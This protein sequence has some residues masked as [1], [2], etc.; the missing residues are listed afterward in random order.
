MTHAAVDGRFI[1]RESLMRSLYRLGAVV[2]AATIIA[3]GVAAGTS[4]AKTASHARAAAA[5]KIA[6]VMP[7]STCASRFEQQDKPD[8]VKAVHELDPSIQ[9]IADNA[10]GS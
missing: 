4:S 7:C 3:V 10:Q 1:R 8:F 6:F 9:V 2:G 5:I